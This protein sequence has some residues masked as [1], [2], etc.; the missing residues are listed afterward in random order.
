VGSLLHSAGGWQRPRIRAAVGRGGPARSR[1]PRER[2][3]A[4]G[5]LERGRRTERARFAEHVETDAV[6]VRRLADEVNSALK[7]CDAYGADV[8]L[9][10]PPLDSALVSPVARAATTSATIVQIGAHAPLQNLLP[11]FGTH[12]RAALEV[13]DVEIQCTAPVAVVAVVREAL[14]AFAEPGAP[15]WSALERVLQHVIADRVSI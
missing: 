6:T 3:D 4:D 12:R 2:G 10:P 14:D 15:R 7:A 13:C 8:S 1:R 9:D 11:K 5:E